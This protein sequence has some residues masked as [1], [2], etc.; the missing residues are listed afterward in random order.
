M[1]LASASGLI[2]N[3]KEYM[4]R[5]IQQ[6]P[7]I[8]TLTS[9]MLTVTTGSIAH[10]F[11]FGSLTVVM[12]LFTWIIQFLLD[13][14]LRSAMP[15]KDLEWSRSTVDVCKIIPGPES[16]KKFEY[17]KYGNHNTSSVP[18][19]WITSMGFLFGY[20]ISNG[21]DTLDAPILTGSDPTGNNMRYTQ[22]IH[23]I[24]S[25]FIVFFL[26]VGT[27]YYFM[28]H[29]EGSGSLGKVLGGL[30]GFVSI[31]IGVGFYNLSRVCGARSSDLFGVLSQMLPPSAMSPSPV[32]CTET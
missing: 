20:F 17:Y 1:S 31:L 3:T 27:R 22:A 9:F 19:Y 21:M 5:G 29:C 8:M 2:A 10:S 4:Y 6:L 13:Y 28:S 11:I 12:P 16:F 30:F 25:T 14:I 23:I 24:V 18:S 32:V 15:G 7:L 26:I